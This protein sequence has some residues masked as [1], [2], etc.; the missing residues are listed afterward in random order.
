MLSPSSP[1]TISEPRWLLQEPLW[2]SIFASRTAGELGEWALRRGAL[3]SFVYEFVRFGLKQA[4]ACLFGG[5]MVFLLV[6][7]YLWYPQGAALARYDFLVLASLLIQVLLL[8]FRL[9]T[10]DEAK[11]IL[12]F[13]IVGTVM[14]IF[15]THMGSWQYPEA[16][17][18][19]IGGVPLF[20]GFM[21]ASVGSYI[22]RAWRMFGFR[23]TNHPSPLVTVSLSFAIYANF[24]TH[25]YVA[26]LRWVIMALLMVA[27]GRTSVHFKIW[28]HY[29][30]MPL[31]LGFFL[32][33]LFIWFAENIGT[34]TKAWIYPS[35]LNGWAMVSPQKLIAWYMLIVISYVMVSLV[36]K[37]KT[38]ASA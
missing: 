23:F 32:V 4:W 10:I 20:T 9:E 19:R 24:F 37:V 36:N 2:I 14:E 38:L 31:A 3:A 33:A 30:R 1:K 28:R 22:A 15:K 7:T 11:V 12:M 26:D 34:L 16:S 17:L 8:V 6:T 18:L 27:F 21:Y 29:R 25:H 35:Q 13:H 5:L